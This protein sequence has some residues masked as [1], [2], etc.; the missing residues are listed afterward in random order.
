MNFTK[1]TVITFANKQDSELVFSTRTVQIPT[2]T[3][4][5][6]IVDGDH[7]IV[8]RNWPST[9]TANYWIQYITNLAEKVD[10]S[11]V[12]AEVVDYTA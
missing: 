3:Q 1:T 5:K 4:P 9:T 6:V 8:K 2:D 12:S 7:V 11:L 10:V